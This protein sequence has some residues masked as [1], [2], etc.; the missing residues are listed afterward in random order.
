MAG[1]PLVKGAG[2]A[3]LACGEEVGQVFFYKVR[4]RL[5]PFSSFSSNFPAYL[6]LIGVGRRGGRATGEGGWQCR[7]S[8]RRRS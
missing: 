3:G 8:L 5:F 4:K 6:E 2:D 7:L 1:G